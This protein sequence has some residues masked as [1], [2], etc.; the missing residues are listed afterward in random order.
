MILKS[1]QQLMN[2]RSS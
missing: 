2:W 1:L